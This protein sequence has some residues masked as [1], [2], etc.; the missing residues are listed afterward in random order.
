MEE[1]IEKVKNEYEDSFK[2]YSSKNSNEFIILQ[3]TNEKLK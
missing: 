1:E 2:E 3:Q